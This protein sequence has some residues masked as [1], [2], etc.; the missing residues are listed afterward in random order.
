M[1]LH[2]F[3]MSYNIVQFRSANHKFNYLCKK[4][5]KIL[6]SRLRFNLRKKLVSHKMELTLLKIGKFER[7]IN[8]I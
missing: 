6:K 8:L 4:F 1:K 2:S 5:I 3:C 7:N